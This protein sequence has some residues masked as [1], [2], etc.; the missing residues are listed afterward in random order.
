MGVGWMGV[1]REFGGV[2]AKTINVALEW[3]TR[4]MLHSNRLLALFSYSRLD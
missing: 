1:G 2:G 3:S 4:K